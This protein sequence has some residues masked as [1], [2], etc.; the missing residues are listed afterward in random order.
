[1]SEQAKKV[2]KITGQERIIS[3]FRNICRANL[4]ILLR[5]NNDKTLAVRG[6]T[7]G[8]DLTV[9]GEVSINGLFINEV[10]ENGIAYLK[11]AKEIQAEFIMM[12]MKVVFFTTI[13][14]MT[15]NSIWISIPEQL[16]SLD[17]RKNLRVN[18]KPE[19]MAFYSSPLSQ[20]H[21]DLTWVPH[22]SQYQSFNNR[23][24]IFN[25][26]MGGICLTSNFPGVE[27]LFTIYPEHK[28]GFLHL[29]M[30]QPLPISVKIKWIKKIPKTIEEAGGNF[31]T[32]IDYRIGCEFYDLS[33]QAKS[34]VITFIQKLSEGYAI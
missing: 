21:Q 6:K 25:V 13:I 3:A 8:L 2:V 31:Y 14:Q 22:F 11:N 24:K 33:D 23:I 16:M 26:S 12:S 30:L 5:H 18:T 20:G 1:M 29:P 7:A 19:I 32:K 4:S 15:K 17:R 34:S 28:N 10:S 27:K 9:A